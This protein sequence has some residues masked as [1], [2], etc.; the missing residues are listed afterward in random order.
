MTIE[1]SLEKMRKKDEERKLEEQ[2]K[3]EEARKKFEEEK[4][5]QLEQENK[6]LKERLKKYETRIQGIANTQQEVIIKI[7]L[8]LLIKDW[9]QPKDELDQNIIKLITDPDFAEIYTNTLILKDPMRRLEYVFMKGLEKEVFNTLPDNTDLFTRLAPL[10]LN[11]ICPY[12]KRREKE[13]DVFDNCFIE[14]K[15]DNAICHGRHD[16]CVIFKQRTKEFITG[17]KPF[18]NPPKTYKP[19]QLLIDEQER[20]D[21]ERKLLQEIERYWRDDDL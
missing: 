16:I 14:G 19:P 7:H 8:R 21:R 10:G 4:R 17:E 15:K 20:E 13:E 2:K 5:I 1:D 12:F 9:P 11:V 3:I 18:I 6:V